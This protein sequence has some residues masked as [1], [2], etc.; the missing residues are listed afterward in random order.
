MAGHAVGTQQANNGGDARRHQRGQPY[1]RRP[2]VRTGFTAAAD[3]VYVL[4]DK[5][6]TNHRPGEIG[7]RTVKPH[8]CAIR[9]FNSDDFSPGD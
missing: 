1:L 6:W 9:F 5:A 7:F 2:G 4:I 8:C 3:Q